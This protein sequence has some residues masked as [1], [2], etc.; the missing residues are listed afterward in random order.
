M[1]GSLVV[2][3]CADQQAGLRKGSSERH[4]TNQLASSRSRGQDEMTQV[5]SGDRVSWR[6]PEEIETPWDLQSEE[7]P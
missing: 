4:W 2:P 5:L 1:N 3:G 7:Q 6:D